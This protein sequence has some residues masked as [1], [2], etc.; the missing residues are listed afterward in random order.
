MSF[1]KG[2]KFIGKFTTWEFTGDIIY[3]IESG[4]TLLCMK[5]TMG[6]AGHQWF[7]IQCFI[8]GEI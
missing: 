3:H 5:D 2:A 6:G 1:S 4:D 8:K 7:S